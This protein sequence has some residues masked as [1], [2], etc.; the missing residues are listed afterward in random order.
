[1]FNAHHMCSV[2]S[3]TAAARKR[4]TNVSLNP[5]LLEQARE[6]SV[7]VSQACERGLEDEVRKAR[8]AAW[9]EA[10]QAALESSNAYVEKHGLPLARYRLF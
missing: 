3:K 1:M 9:L 8:A 4:P 7:N 10:N 5:S 2:M 6:L